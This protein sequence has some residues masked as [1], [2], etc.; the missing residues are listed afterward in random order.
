M[1]QNLLGFLSSI[2]KTLT[3]LQV[4]EKNLLTASFKIYHKFILQYFGPARSF[5]QFKF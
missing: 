5:A 1:K 4:R 3:L 2:L